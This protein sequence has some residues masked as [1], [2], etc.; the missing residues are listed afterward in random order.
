MKS[1]DFPPDIK[2]NTLMEK[3]AK[4][5]NQ[6]EILK[7]FERVLNAKISLKLELKKI[8]LKPVTEIKKEEPSPSLV[9]MAKEVFGS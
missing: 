3:I 8:N 7:A 6:N 9:E 2:S 4:P 1:R 5:T